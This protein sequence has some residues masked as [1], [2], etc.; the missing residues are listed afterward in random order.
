MK[1]NRFLIYLLFINSLIF[2][3]N[4][5]WS[6]RNFSGGY[7]SLGFQIGKTTANSRFIDIQISPMFVLIGPYKHS[8][9]GYLFFGS[10]IGKRFSKGK[11]LVYFDVNLNFWNTLLSFGSGKGIVLDK[12]NKY[13]RTKNWGGLGFLPFI[14]C[15][16]NHVI[17]KNK[18][19]QMGT[20]GVI[21][22]PFFG[23]NF[24][25]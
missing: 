24:H 7:V 10:S 19:K 3:E 23:N 13:S 20:M 21:P 6:K 25:P 9:P 12:D 22:F 1:K 11:S 5:R 4:N 15:F 8:F 2:A 16:D 18:I 14:L 17:D